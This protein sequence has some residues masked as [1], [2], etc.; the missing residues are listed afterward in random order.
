M[1]IVVIAASETIRENSTMKATTLFMKN[2]NF[3]Y[4]ATNIGFGALLALLVL[5]QISA[6]AAEVKSSGADKFNSLKPAGDSGGV[7]NFRRRSGNR[8]LRAVASFP[9]RD[10]PR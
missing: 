2:G 1:M 6:N 4:V 5:T 3:L 10:D 8:F 9:R 7:C